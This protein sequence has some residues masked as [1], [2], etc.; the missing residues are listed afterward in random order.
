[1]RVALHTKVRPDRVAEYEAA[2][3]D[4]P[5]ELTEPEKPPVGIAWQARTAAL[6]DAVHDHSEAGPDAGLPVAGELP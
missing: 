1:M 2:H 5:V 6:L 4:V 3:R